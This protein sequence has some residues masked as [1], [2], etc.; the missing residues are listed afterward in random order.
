[1]LREAGSAVARPR[2][3]V[4]SAV[5]AQPHA[6]TDSIFGIVRENLGGV[7][8]QAVY[9]VL[10]VL[11]AAALV[12][13]FEPMGSVARY[14]APVGDKHHH[15]VCRSCGA[16]ADVDGVAGSAACLMPIDDSGY[17]V[18]GAEVALWGRCARC[19]AAPDG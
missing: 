18:D 4:L 9:D 12:R 3:A 7:S 8:R 1:M 5:H 14:E 16:I 10:R 11:T 15:V 19:V 6:D 2:M 17:E 13:R